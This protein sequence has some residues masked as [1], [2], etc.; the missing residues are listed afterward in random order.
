MLG[1]MELARSYYHCPTC[2][3]GHLPWEQTLGLNSQRLTPAAS[4]ITCMLGV[5][6]CFAE[7]SERTL[8]KACG[9]RLS[10]STVERVTEST[11]ERL[12][13]LLEQKV[14]FGEAES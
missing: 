2:G 7:V 3:K 13:K 1:E 9:L 12:G 14:K 11:G 4:E 10:E 5:L 6:T 8:R